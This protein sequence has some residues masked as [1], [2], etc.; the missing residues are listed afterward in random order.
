[1]GRVALSDG[2]ES[3][4]DPR[5]AYVFPGQGSQKV[6]MGRSW[7]EA[8]PEAAA[9]FTVANEA[10]GFD[11]ARLCWEGPEAALQLT[12]NTQ[13]AILTVSAA[14]HAVLAARGRGDADAVAGHSLGEYSAHVAAGTLTLADALRLVRMRGRLMQQA[15]PVGEGAMTAVLGLDADAV[16][17]L[18]DEA[19]Q[20]EV[21]SVANFNSPEQTVL[22]GHRGAIERAMALAKERGAKRALPLPVSAPFHCALMAPARRGLEPALASTAF[23]D[24]RMPVVTNIDAR[25]VFAAAD[26]RSALARQVDG[27]V[28]WV[29]SVLQMAGEL[30]IRRFVEV[31]PGSVLTGLIRRI[32]PEAETLALADPAAL[33]KL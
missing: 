29:D 19:A 2:S 7:A 9:V 31:G 30:G 8:F 18:A 33:E 23:A 15:V 25:P 32:A 24:P 5:T 17:A 16:A 13:P 20:G 14:I 11:L 3:T 12:E 27:P 21:C 1:V 4:M 22:A 26:A 6:G 10:L 28:R